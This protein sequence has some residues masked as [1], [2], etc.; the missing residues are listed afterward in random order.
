[1]NCASHENARGA[2]PS[3]RQGFSL[4]EMLVA[5]GIMIVL[6]GVMLGYSRTSER[7][8]ALISDRDVVISVINHVRDL[9][10]ANTYIV[11]PSTC[12]Y[13]ITFIGNTMNIYSTVK[14]GTGACPDPSLGGAIVE[15]HSLDPRLSFQA[16]PAFLFFTSPYLSVTST[17][18]FPVI[19]TLTAGTSATDMSLEVSGGGTAT[20]IF[21]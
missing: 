8:V 11:G 16:R 2:R 20:A 4:I 5:I 15:T 13:G 17:S 18:A 21:Q 19:I 10:L 9:A 7:Q 1:M 14:D 6:S 12:G 3:G